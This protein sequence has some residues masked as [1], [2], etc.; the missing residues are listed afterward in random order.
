VLK[1]SITDSARARITKISSASAED[2]LLRIAVDGGGCSGYQYIMTMV[3]SDNIATDDIVISE[4]HK[5]LV[6]VDRFSVPF[7][8]NCKLDFVE[9]LSGGSF[10]IKNPNVKGGCGC[11]NSFEYIEEQK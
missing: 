2:V 8:Q 10:N 1:I 7:L 6:V 11:G 5:P 4:D 9:N 3:N